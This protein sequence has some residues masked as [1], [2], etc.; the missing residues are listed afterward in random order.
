MIEIKSEDNNLM[1]CTI[2]Q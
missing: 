1:F 2:R